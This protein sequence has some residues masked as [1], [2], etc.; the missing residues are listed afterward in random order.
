MDILCGKTA[1]VIFIG[2][3]YMK[4]IHK[5]IEPCMHEMHLSTKR[6]KMLLS[7]LIFTNTKLVC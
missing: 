7:I 1:H 4:K 6:H 2:R 3:H 5:R